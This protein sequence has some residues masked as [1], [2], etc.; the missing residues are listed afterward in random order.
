MSWKKMRRGGEGGLPST[1]GRYLLWLEPP[2]VENNGHYVHFSWRDGSFCIRDYLEGLESQ[3]SGDVTP[4]AIWESA[5][6]R[7]PATGKLYVPVKDFD[8][9]TGKLAELTE[10][11]RVANG[12]SGFSPSLSELAPDSVEKRN[13]TG[14]TTP[15]IKEEEKEHQGIYE[16]FIGRWRERVGFEIIDG[17]VGCSARYKSEPLLWVFPTY[18]QIAP[19]GKGNT[20]FNEVML[21]RDQH[22]NESHQKSIKFDSPHF[23][24]QRFD[25][26]TKEVQKM[27]RETDGGEHKTQ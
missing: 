7:I 12:S 22:F 23:S 26:F 5:S 21:L 11:R 25:A 24:W 27:F 9:W 4:S 20:H 6:D 15:Q 1:R 16:K 14:G 13:D 19:Q 8:F 10:K 2:Q 18:F 17:T 3:Q